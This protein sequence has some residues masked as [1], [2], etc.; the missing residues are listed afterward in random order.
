MIRGLPHSREATC[1]RSSEIIHLNITPATLISQDKSWLISDYLC[2]AA[3]YWKPCPPFPPTKQNLK[4]IKPIPK[5]NHLKGYLN[6][7]VPFCLIKWLIESFDDPWTH[8]V[9]GNRSLGDF[10]NTSGIKL[11]ANRKAGHCNHCHNFAAFLPILQKSGALQRSHTLSL[12]IKHHH[13]ISY[14]LRLLRY[15]YHRIFWCLN[16]WEW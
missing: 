10:L 6:G 14:V 9:S 15:K 12:W 8:N 7:D 16:I 13:M 11:N 4:H 3:F 2:P 5:Y 1:Y